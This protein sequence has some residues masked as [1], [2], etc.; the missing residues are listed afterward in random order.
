MTIQALGKITP[1]G[2]ELVAGLEKKN[3]FYPFPEGPAQ[4][5]KATKNIPSWGIEKGDFAYMDYSHD[6]DHAEVFHGDG[7]KDKN[8]NDISRK[9]KDVRNLDGTRNHEKRKEALGWELKNKTWSFKQDRFRSIKDFI[10]QKF[11]S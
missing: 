5:Y 3:R 11:N 4:I 9:A 2:R 10:N 1:A 8:G 6:G 7:T